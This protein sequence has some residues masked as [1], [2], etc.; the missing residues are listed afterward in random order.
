MSYTEFDAEALI[1]SCQIPNLAQQPLVDPVTWPGAVQLDVLNPTDIVSKPLCRGEADLDIAVVM[2]V[3]DEADIIGQNL[4][5]LYFLG[6][7][8]FVIIDN[9]SKDGTSDILTAFRQGHID[10]EMLVVFDP[11]VRLIQSE[12]TTGAFQFAINIWPSCKWVFPIDADEFLIP[13]RGFQPLHE[14][15]AEFDGIILPKVN[16]FILRGDDP[17][18]EVGKSPFGRMPLRTGKWA[19]PPKI[20]LRANATYQISQGNHKILRTDG[21]ASR[22]AQAG[23]ADMFYREYQVRNYQHFRTKVTNGGKAIREAM[24]ATGRQLGGAHWLNWYELYLA[25]GDEAL[26]ALFERDFQRN[27]GDGLVLDPFE[28]S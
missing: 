2:M 14:L 24:A 8:K 17:G 23:A 5:W 13:Q 21:V 12:K 22:Y 6:I 18:S 15:G 16:H 10:L 1:W 7:R 20:A 28:P 26:R 25:G 9:E 19:L 11:I 4:D 3:K 27:I